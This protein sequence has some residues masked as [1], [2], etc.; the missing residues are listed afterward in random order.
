MLARYANLKMANALFNVKC[1]GRYAG[2]VDRFPV[3]DDKVSWSVDWPDYRPVDYT[4][5]V[6]EKMPVWADVDFRYFIDK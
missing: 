3:P 1:R 4:A 5:P 2:G 6:V